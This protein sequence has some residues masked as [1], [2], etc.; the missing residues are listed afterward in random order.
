VKLWRI[1]QL[2]EELPARLPFTRHPY[3][4]VMPVQQFSRRDI[5]IYTTWLLAWFMVGVIA[6]GWHAPFAGIG[7]LL[8]GPVAYVTYLYLA[9]TK[10]PYYGRRCYMGG[11]QCAKRLFAARVGDYTLAEDLIV[12]ALWIGVS[13]YP[14]IFLIYYSDWVALVA[15]CL[16]AIGW[17][18]IHKRHVCAKCR[19]VRCALNPRF[20][21]RAAR[22]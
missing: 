16:L 21:G 18:I 6:V 13:I 7:Y 1:A 17:Q 10:C 4:H 19:N 11:G 14:V 12:P 20:V 5:A 8:L 3:R 22:N 9:C 2:L 15:Y